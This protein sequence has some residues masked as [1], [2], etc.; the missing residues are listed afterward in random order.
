MKKKLVNLL[1]LILLI[2]IILVGILAIK[3]NNIIQQNNNSNSLPYFNLPDIYQEGVY[4]SSEEIIKNSS[5]KLILIN[6]FAS[7]CVTCHF[8][9]DMLLSLSSNEEID[10]YG[11]SFNDIEENTIKYLEKNKN[12][13]IR[14]LSDNQGKLSN[15][16][17]IIGVPETLIIKNN[18]IIYRHQGNLTEDVNQYIIDMFSLDK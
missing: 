2:L 9:H 11:I 12:P 7:W 4:L 13:F 17:N 15:S 8:E 14:V 6:F 5:N 3:K 16:L 18:K 1:P 10:I